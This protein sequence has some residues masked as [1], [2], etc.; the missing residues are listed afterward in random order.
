MDIKHGHL[1]STVFHDAD[2][3]KRHEEFNI[4]VQ[5]LFEQYARDLLMRM[6]QIL[7]PQDMPHRRNP[8]H[9]AA[10]SK[11]T[12]CFKCIEALLNFDLETDVEGYDEFIKLFFELQ[13][14]ETQEERKFDPR[15]YHGI[16][17]EFK[18]LM[19]PQE[20]GAVTRDFR[21]Q[22]RL[23]LKEVLDAQDANFH[24]PLHVSS[25]FGD[26]KASRFMVKLGADPNSPAFAQRPLEV[27][28]DKFVR[29]VLQNLNDAAF[30]AN[31]KDLKHLVN[32]GNKIDN[33]L[34]IFGEAPIHKAV[35]SKVKEAQKS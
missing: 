32:C 3:V 27:G 14:L 18:H 11:F 5:S 17:G 28:K 8:I 12:K 21:L 34:S 29:G 4:R 30:Q 20:Y 24:S 9:Y 31:E 25:Y 1:V 6:R 13:L 26:F 23:L 16:L 35:L 19:S 7:V 22:V 2:T 33:K 10:M 15:K